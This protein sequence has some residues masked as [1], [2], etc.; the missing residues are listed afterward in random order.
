M[1]S[2]FLF[3]EP[4][5][6]FF[7]V[8]QVGAIYSRLLARSLLWPS[9]GMSLCG[10]NTGEETKCV[11]VSLCGW[12]CHF[13]GQSQPSHLVANLKKQNIFLTIRSTRSEWTFCTE[14]G[15]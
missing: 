1:A 2:G 4:N 6:V 3:Y 8:S 15:L 14:M 7:K 13:C 9:V 5:R 12:R 11:V 10:H